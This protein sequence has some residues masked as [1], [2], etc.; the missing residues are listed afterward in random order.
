MAAGKD[1]GEFSAL[2]FGDK[3]RLRD[4]SECKFC[5]NLGKELKELREELS[6]AK[7]IINLLQSENN[8]TECAS[9]NT[10]EPQ[11]NYVNANKTKEEKWTE[12]VTVH[13]R[14]KQNR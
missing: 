14:I 10:T 12:V 6:S 5:I 1:E 4:V 11:C 8:P 7:L 9:Y 13:H 3:T 2:F